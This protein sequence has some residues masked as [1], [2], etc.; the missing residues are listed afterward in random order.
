MS[1]RRQFANFFIVG[2]ELRRLHNTRIQRL[3]RAVLDEID[4]QRLRDKHPCPECAD[5]TEMYQF[6]HSS[7]IQQRPID[8][9][10]FGVFQGDSIREWSAMNRDPQSRFY[11]FDSFEGL[12]ETWRARQEKGHFDVGGTIPEIADPRVNF[13]KGWFDKTVPDFARDFAP[14]S[15]LVLHLD[16]DLYSSTLIPLIYFGPFLRNGSLLIFDE[17]YD[18]NH[19]FKAFQDFLKISRRAYRVVCQMENYQKVCI[20]LL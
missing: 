11:G 5:R 14:Q 1:T 9:L 16:A 12:P 10:E 2:C 7:F 13:I 3:V 18:R 8:F 6:I 4:L 15:R 20:E 19:E 17:F